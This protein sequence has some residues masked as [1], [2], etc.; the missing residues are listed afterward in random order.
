MYKYAFPLPAVNNDRFIPSVLLCSY[1]LVNEVNHPCPCAWSP[2]LW[3]GSEMKLLHNSML[4]SGL[5]DDRILFIIMI[6]N[7]L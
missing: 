1:D 6:I 3:P 5:Q 7:F 4:V 2:T